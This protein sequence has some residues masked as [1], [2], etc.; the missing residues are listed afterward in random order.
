MDLTEF[1]DLTQ[2]RI[3]K[4]EGCVL[5]I[6]KVSKGYATVG[7]GHLMLPTD[8]FSN[9]LTQ[10]QAEQ[11]FQGDFG[12]AVQGAE[13]HPAYSKLDPV[14]QSCLIDIAF[15]MGGAWW[16]G[17]PACTQALIDG[18]Y[19]LAAANLL[20]NDVNSKTPTE[21]L[22]DVPARAKRNA[23]LLEDGSEDDLRSYC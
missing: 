18:N 17:F 5:N 14:R 20:Y 6:Y 1:L 11:L 10:D 16:H 2:T 19:S 12:I 4:E 3:K 15:N 8:N 9:P 23:K 7:Y 22:R 13:K 21:Y